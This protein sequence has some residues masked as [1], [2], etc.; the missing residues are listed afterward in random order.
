MGNQSLKNH[1]LERQT[2]ST[3]GPGSAWYVIFYNC[4]LNF[5]LLL[6]NMLHLIYGIADAL[7]SIITSTEFDTIINF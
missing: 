3:G 5:A 6:F 4:P 1:T 7:I 2:Y